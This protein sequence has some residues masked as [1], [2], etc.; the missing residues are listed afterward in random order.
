MVVAGQSWPGRGGGPSH[1][2]PILVSARLK[3]LNDCRL[4]Y[5]EYQFNFG[6]KSG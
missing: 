3:K 1:P 6:P 5:F 2:D 4:A